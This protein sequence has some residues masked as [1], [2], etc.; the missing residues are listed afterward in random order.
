MFASKILSHQGGVGDTL[1]S[2][3]RSCV[4]YV[5]QKIGT[6][7]DTVNDVEKTVDGV[8]STV[9]NIDTMVNDVEEKVNG[10]EEKFKSVDEKLDAMKEQIT[11][12]QKNV[13]KKNLQ[14]DKKFMAEI[15]EEMKAEAKATWQPR[16]G[17]FLNK[18]SLIRHI[19]KS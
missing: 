9:N 5:E 10:M 4:I 17:I 14:C 8:E 13:L 6:V 12:L 16:S 1:T 3:M 7:E 15:R 19:D 2:T 18:S 11:Y